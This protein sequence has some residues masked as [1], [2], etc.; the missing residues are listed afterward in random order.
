MSAATPRTRSGISTRRARAHRILAA[1]VTEAT[2][3]GN[4]P[5]EAEEFLARLRAIDA[6]TSQLL[7]LAFIA[8]RRQAEP[9][10]EAADQWPTRARAWLK[11][12]QIGFQRRELL[13]IRDEWL[14]KTYGEAAAS[15]PDSTDDAT[16]AQGSST[17]SGE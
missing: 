4:A 13:R 10:A 6:E 17:T 9:R 11:E 15:P 1:A 7:R 5:F 16:T 8:T 14:A 3:E 2:T 12:H